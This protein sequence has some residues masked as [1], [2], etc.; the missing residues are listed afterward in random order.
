MDVQPKILRKSLL[1]G[2]RQAEGVAV[3]ID[4]FRAFTSAAFMVD[5]GA[6]QLVLLAEPAD[7]LRLKAEEGYLAVGEEGGRKVVGFDLGNSPS[8]I[9]AAGR[10]FFAGRSVAQRTSAGVAGAVAAAHHADVVVLGSYVTA[11]ASVRYI[12]S[13]SPPP[14]TVSLVAMG[15]AG[16]EVTLEDEACADYLEHL[17]VGRPYDHL[18]ALQKIVQH[19][20]AQKFLQGDQPHYPRE[21]P[22][23]CLQRDL[24]AFALVASWEDGRLVARRAEAPPL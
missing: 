15:S 14:K 19:Q 21:D 23:Y 20:A 12:Q 3:I 7:V 2:A 22:I 9:L 24:F 8:E 18:S 10:S 17:L 13:M 6:Q 1:T 5:L 4:V 16:E 11:C